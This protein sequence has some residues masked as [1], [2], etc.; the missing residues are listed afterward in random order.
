MKSEDEIAHEKVF[1]NAQ[2]IM[3]GAP[4]SWGECTASG[5][6]WMSGESAFFKNAC[7]QLFLFLIKGY[8]L[9]APFFGPL[10]RF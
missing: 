9:G 7:V 5:L 2:G 4:G 3:R 1:G 8:F 6:R 10:K